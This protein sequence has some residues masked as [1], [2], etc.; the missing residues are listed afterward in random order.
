MI[1][2]VQQLP[3]LYS[4]VSRSVDQE[5]TRHHIETLQV[6]P[7][8]GTSVRR[9]DDVLAL[10]GFREI[11][12]SFVLDRKDPHLYLCFEKLEY[13]TLIF[14][15][16]FASLNELEPREVHF[17]LNHRFFQK[18]PTRQRRVAPN[19][20]SMNVIFSEIRTPSSA[21]S[22]TRMVRLSVSEAETRPDISDHLADATQRNA[23]R[24]PLR[25]MKEQIM[26]RTGTI[27]SRRSR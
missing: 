11:N 1:V 3:K 10:V 14:S 18:W 8:F 21:L 26:K 20:K 24:K 4:K 27:P 17:N 23:P 12:P 7:S 13:T 19:A 9:I 5:R 25:P 2:P 15:T 22:S 16:R 6:I